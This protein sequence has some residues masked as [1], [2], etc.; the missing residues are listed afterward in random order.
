[1]RS[2]L[3]QVLMC[4]RMAVIVRVPLVPGIIP[5]LSGHQIRKFTALCGAELPAPVLQ[6]L[7]ELGNQEEAVAEFGI[8]HATRQC[9]EL[10]QAG[11]PGVHFYTLNKARSTTRILRNLGA[12]A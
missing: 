2:V 4:V 11:A 12:A 3:V 5:I 7:D 6:R 10:L 1:M 8:E 9:Q